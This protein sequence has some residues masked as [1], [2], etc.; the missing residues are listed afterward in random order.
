MINLVLEKGKIQFEISRD[1][2][3]R[4]NIHFSSK[5]LSLAKADYESS[6]RQAEGPRQLRVK[7]AP[8]YPTIASEK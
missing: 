4:S 8:E 7:V 5:F 2:L 6:G 3:D 1:A